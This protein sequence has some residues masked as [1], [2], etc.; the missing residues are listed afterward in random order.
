MG[1]LRVAIHGVA[2]SEGLL[3][4]LREKGLELVEMDGEGVT[5][6]LGPDERRWDEGLLFLQEDLARMAP[7]G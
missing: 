3:R 6:D 7:A 5:L 4:R 2:P 1:S